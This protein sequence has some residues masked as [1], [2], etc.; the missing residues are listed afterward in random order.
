MPTD[1]ELL[2]EQ[3]R[4][5]HDARLVARRDEHPRALRRKPLRDRKPDPHAAAS[6]DRK[7]A[8]QS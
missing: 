5:V 3:S 2:F 4:L 8:L 7:L 6:D 1:A